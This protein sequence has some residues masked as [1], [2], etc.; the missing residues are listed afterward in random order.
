MADQVKH[1]PGRQAGRPGMRLLGAVGRPELVAPVVQRNI[2]VWP[3]PTRA[4]ARWQSGGGG[5]GEDGCR[6]GR[7]G[8]WGSR[9][10]EAVNS[11]G[12]GWTRQASGDPLAGSVHHR[13]G[14]QHAGLTA[15]RRLR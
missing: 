12:R 2:G 13:A 1:D 6:Y 10:G 11:V 3:P 9:L 7:F 15:A 8:L 4:G 5:G 14:H